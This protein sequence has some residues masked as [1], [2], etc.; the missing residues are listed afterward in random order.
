ML[1]V[2]PL[3]MDTVIFIQFPSLKGIVQRILRG[4]NNKLK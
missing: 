3:K 4:F 1:L 2:L